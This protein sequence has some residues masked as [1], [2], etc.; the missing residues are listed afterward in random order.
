MR[1]QL[2]LEPARGVPRRSRWP[3]AVGASSGRSPWQHTGRERGTELLATSASASTS[4]SLVRWCVKQGRN[5]NAP[6]IVVP[7]VSTRPSRCIASSS[8]RLWASRQTGSSSPAGCAG[9]RRPRTA[10]RPAARDRAPRAPPRPAAGRGAG[11]SRSRPR[12][13]RRR[14]PRTPSRDRAPAVSDAPRIT[15]PQP[16]MPA[17]TA[18]CSASGAAANVMRAACTLGTMPWSAIATSV[19]LSTVASARVGRLPVSSRLK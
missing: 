5:A 19:A 6:R 17:A 10:A 18:P 12:G 8:T 11:R 2:D 9:R 16:R 4:P 13:R 14:R 3:Q 1:R 15:E 7:D